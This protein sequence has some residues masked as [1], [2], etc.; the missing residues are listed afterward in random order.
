[1]KSPIESNSLVGGK[2]YWKDS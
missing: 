2:I 1:M